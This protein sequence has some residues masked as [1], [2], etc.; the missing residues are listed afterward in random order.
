VARV[1]IRGTGGSD[2]R[3]IPYEYS[4]QAHDDGEAVIAWLSEQDWSNGNVGMF[5]ISWGGFNSI[6]MALRAPGNAALF[7]ATL[8]ALKTAPDRSIGLTNY[9]D[10]DIR[11]GHRRDIEGYA[12]ALEYFDRR[13]PG[14]P[15]LM[16]DEDLMIICADHGR[17]PLRP[18]SDHTRK[19]VPVRPAAPGCRPAQSAS[20]KP[21]PISGRT[22]R[23]SST[24]LRWVMARPS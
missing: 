4:D 21:L 19:H 2:G 15:A 11:Y 12:T 8:K 13:L 3:L 16:N 24:F 20:A 6:Q 17:N 14:L 9:V 23:T 7:D 1:D 10:F 18:G 22:G 5:G